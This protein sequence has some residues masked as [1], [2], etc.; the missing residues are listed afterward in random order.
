MSTGLTLFRGR[1]VTND[2][3]NLGLCFVN[4]GNSTSKGQ[5][6]HLVNSLLDIWR[7]FV[8]REVRTSQGVA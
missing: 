8:L 5:A 6:S 1:R 7:E 2:K 4:E 3:I